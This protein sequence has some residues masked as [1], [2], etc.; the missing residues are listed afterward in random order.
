MKRFVLLL[1]LAA[2][3]AGTAAAHTIMVF[4][5]GMT[6]P[7]PEDGLRYYLT[8]VE[9]GV[10]DVFFSNGDIVFNAGSYQ[11][12]DA[13]AA[14]STPEIDRQY[15]IRSQARDGGADRVIE[16]TVNFKQVD[17]NTYVP[18]YADYQYVD[19]AGKRVVRS[20]TVSVNDQGAGDHPP[21]DRV[22][23]LVGE[24]VAKEA[25]APD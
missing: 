15:T 23:F 8:A 18:D 4:V 16:V 13:S 17:S 11:T 10:M 22:C 25:I 24:S 9:A 7:V 19:L 2:G 5:E 20:G 21:T 6:T 1:L 12:R 14:E 3:I